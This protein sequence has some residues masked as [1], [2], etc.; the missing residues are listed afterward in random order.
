MK[1]YHL[2]SGL[3]ALAFLLLAG[4]IAD[5]PREPEEMAMEAADESGTAQETDAAESEPLATAEADAPAA[6]E[7]APPCT[8]APEAA[9]KIWGVGLVSFPSE[10]KAK[11][12]Q[13]KLAARGY[14][15]ET[16]LTRVR[17]KT[18]YRVAVGGFKS[19]AD[20]RRFRNAARAMGYKTA[21]LLPPA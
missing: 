17:G 13:E 8:A 18:W 16:F 19:K 7:L 9:E 1:K 11:Q 6:S 15:A 5:P 4:C 20:A 12:A 3:T 21:W 10:T 2:A 14:A